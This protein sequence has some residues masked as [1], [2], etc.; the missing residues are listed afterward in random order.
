MYTHGHHNNVYPEYLRYN[1]DID[2]HQQYT[3]GQYNNVYPGY[4]RYS[5]IVQRQQYIPRIIIKMCIQST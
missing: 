5:D 3:Q 4:I 1:S 2:K